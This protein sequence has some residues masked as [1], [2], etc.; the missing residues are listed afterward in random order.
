MTQNPTENL[1]FTNSLKVSLGVIR[2][3]GMLLRVMYSIH[4]HT[5]GAFHIQ[6]SYVTCLFYIC[7]FDVQG[8]LMYKAYC[9]IAKMSVPLRVYNLIMYV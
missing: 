5:R 9:S 1:R 8:V 3:Q 6:G 2:N 7:V 4:F